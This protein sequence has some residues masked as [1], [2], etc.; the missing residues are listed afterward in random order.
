MFNV[1]ILHH[2]LMKKVTNTS[3]GRKYDFTEKTEDEVGKNFKL[4]YDSISMAPL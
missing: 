2:N 4:P 1:Q 3:S